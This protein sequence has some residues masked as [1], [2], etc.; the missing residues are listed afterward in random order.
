M[1]ERLENI[2]LKVIK[3][4]SDIYLK[5]NEEKCQFLVLGASHDEPVSIKIGNL[6]VQNSTQEKLLGNT[7]D[8]ES[9]TEHHVAGICQKASNELH[10]LSHITPL[11]NQ[12]KIEYLMRAYLIY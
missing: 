5:Q 2:S 1:V 12:G 11:V 3:W 9:T 8:N 4:F 10:A 7:I 6:S